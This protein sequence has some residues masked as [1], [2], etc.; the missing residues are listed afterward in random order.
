MS[1]NYVRQTRLPPTALQ[2]QASVHNRQMQQFYLHKLFDLQSDA[3]FLPLIPFDPVAS[4][5]QMHESV[6]AASDGAQ[7]LPHMSMATGQEPVYNGQKARRYSGQF[8]RQ[9]LFGGKRTDYV[10]YRSG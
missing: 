5:I 4:V 6:S 10:Q 2:I 3:E 7:Y 9:H 1:Q 8:L